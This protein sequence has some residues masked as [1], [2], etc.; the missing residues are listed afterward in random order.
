MDFESEEFSGSKSSYA[1][2]DATGH[3]QR[4][5]GF[6]RA[7]PP[8]SQQKAKP[9]QQKAMSKIAKHQTVESRPDKGDNGRRIYFVVPWQPLCFSNDFKSPRIRLVRQE[10]WKRVLSIDLMWVKVGV[11][12]YRNIIA[13]EFS[14]FS[15]HFFRD[16]ALNEGKILGASRLSCYL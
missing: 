6:Y 7:V 5:P 9:C 3:Q 4:S 13:G 15:F 14:E 8:V 16:I 12:Y 11:S 10:A 1:G 2:S